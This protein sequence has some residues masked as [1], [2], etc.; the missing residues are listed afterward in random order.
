VSAE[1]IPSAE[2]V[3][4]D[5]AAARRRRV[6]ERQAVV[7]EPSVEIDPGL[8]AEDAERAR[9]QQQYKERVMG[10]MAEA[11]AGTPFVVGT[12]VEVEGERIYDQFITVRLE[13]GNELGSIYPDEE[14]GDLTFLPN[15]SL[16]AW[17]GMRV[18]S[19]L[20]KYTFTDP[21]EVGAVAAE[22]EDI[23]ALQQAEFDSYSNSSDFGAEMEMRAE[24]SAQ[25][26]DILETNERVTSVK[27]NTD[28]AQATGDTG[29]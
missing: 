8:S 7:A 5:D 25:V 2:T 12:T 22:L 24:T 9:E 15:D 28:R 4:P 21:A 29:Q 6:P 11:L 16:S 10:E 23:R 18:G 27:Q 14:T 20:D 26:R 17:V 3:S 19:P 1:T 13:N